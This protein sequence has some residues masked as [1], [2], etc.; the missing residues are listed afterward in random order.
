MGFSPARR[1]LVRLI[2]ES[3]SIDGLRDGNMRECGELRVKELMKSGKLQKVWL[4]ST[5]MAFDN[6]EFQ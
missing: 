3:C 1:S 5:T 2:E 4:Q 6:V